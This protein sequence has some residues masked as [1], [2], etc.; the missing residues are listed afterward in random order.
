L[1]APL[2]LIY[3]YQSPIELPITAASPNPIPT[4]RLILSL[5]LYLPP[6][7]FVVLSNVRVDV[8]GVAEGREG[9][10][11]GR[12][13]VVEGGAGIGVLEI[14]DSLVEGKE[15]EESPSHSF[16]ALGSRLR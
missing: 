13:D 15:E 7:A 9:A 5:S 11:E 6:P 12:E 1:L 3:L 16:I 10:V 2:L 14:S 8:E 4:P